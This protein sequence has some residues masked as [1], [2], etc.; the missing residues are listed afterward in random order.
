MKSYIG[1][2]LIIV[3]LCSLIIISCEKNE[4]I[5][6]DCTTKN[7]QSEFK[8][9][10]FRYLLTPYGMRLIQYD[11]TTL[12]SMNTYPFC[13]VGS[14]SIENSKIIKVDGRIVKACADDNDFI[15]LEKYEIV[16]NCTREILELNQQFTLLD[17]KWKVAYIQTN[18][19]TYKP[20]C[21]G[22]SELIF[23]TDGNFDGFMSKN[24]IAGSF[25][26]TTN[27]ISFSN[28]GLGLFI[29]TETQVIFERAFI[30]ALSLMSGSSILNYNINKNQLY[31][32]NPIANSTIKFYTK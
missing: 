1:S 19:V 18:G 3:I 28:A 8:G 17:V 6:N 16:E 10:Y 22:Y 13:T 32:T 25:T 29:G 9:L 2:L 20:P 27:S 14:L 4:S 23:H 5:C 7:R 21:E 26:H 31:V 15:Q 12:K 30:D 11:S 24:F